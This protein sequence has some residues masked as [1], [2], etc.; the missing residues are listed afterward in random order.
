GEETEAKVIKPLNALKAQL[1]NLAKP[2]MAP[3]E[4]R[5]KQAE[6]LI[7]QLKTTSEYA[8]SPKSVDSLAARIAKY[9]R[10]FKTQQTKMA[11]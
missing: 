7:E 11:R 1:K 2:D 9:R 8:E 6:K 4:E 10:S 3:L 5:L